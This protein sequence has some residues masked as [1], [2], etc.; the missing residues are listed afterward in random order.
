MPVTI[1]RIAEVLAEES[2]IPEHWMYLSFAGDEGWRGAVL[3][4]AHGLT[5]AILECNRRKI[6][7]HGE[8][9]GVDVPDEE[10]EKIPTALRFKLLNATEIDQ[11]WGPCATL[12]ELRENHQ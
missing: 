11:Y 10:I 7:P 5:H 12:G 3:V 1:Y 9:L 2:E 8:V 6:N 4:K